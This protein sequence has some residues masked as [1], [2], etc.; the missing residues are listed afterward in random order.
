MLITDCESSSFFLLKYLVEDLL[1]SYY[2]RSMD[3]LIVDI[4]VL[5]ELIRIKFPDVYKHVVDLGI[6]L[7]MA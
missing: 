1:P 2:T 3:G 4:K 6:I 7:L 5:S